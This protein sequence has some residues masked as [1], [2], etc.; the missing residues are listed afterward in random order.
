MERFANE[1][2]SFLKATYAKISFVCCISL[3]CLIF[4][5]QNKYMQK[6]ILNQNFKHES[7][8]IYYIIYYTSHL[9]QNMWTK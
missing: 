7:D 5:Y 9:K 2:L 6:G 3:I 1:N 8:N 4:N